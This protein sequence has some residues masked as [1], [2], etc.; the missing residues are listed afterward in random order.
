MQRFIEQLEGRQLMSA[1]GANCPMA[2]AAAIESASLH[3]VAAP[4]LNTI[5]GTFTGTVK[6][7]IDLGFP[8]G[9]KSFTA[10]LT[11]KITKYNATSGALTGTVT[12]SSSLIGSFT[13]KLNSKKSKLKS[14]RTFTFVFADA[15]SDTSITITGKYTKFTK[16]S[17]NF[18]GEAGGH[19]VDG[20][21]SLTRSS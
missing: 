21:Y 11:V 10:N 17:G 1:G 4:A 6:G 9:D 20:T 13:V 18:S 7:D 2:E 16:V 5:V 3:K 19:D 15:P 8:L 14:D 12:V